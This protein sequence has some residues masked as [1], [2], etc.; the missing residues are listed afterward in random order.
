[1]HVVVDTVAESLS[2]SAEKIEEKTETT[3]A[4][5]SEQVTLTTIPTTESSLKVISPSESHEELESRKDTDD[6]KG[7]QSKV[8][9][10][11][12]PDNLY[13]PEDS[14]QTTTMNSIEKKRPVEG[15]GT[16]VSLDIPVNSHNLTTTTEE[17]SILFD[18]N[19]DAANEAEL[20]TPQTDKINVTITESKDKNSLEAPTTYQD[21][22]T[23]MYTVTSRNGQTGIN[24]FFH[25][26]TLTTTGLFSYTTEVSSTEMNTEA[27]DYTAEEASKTTAL[28][29]S[30]N[31]LETKEFMDVPQSNG[32][33]EFNKNKES[34]IQTTDSA[35]E[36]RTSITELLTTELS[37][38]PSS[39][40]A[41]SGNP[42]NALT[43]VITDRIT[44]DTYY[45]Q[46][47]ETTALPD[48]VNAQANVNSHLNAEKEEQSL[49][50]IDEKLSKDTAENKPSTL[51]IGEKLLGNSEEKS[52]E[53][54]TEKP[55]SLNVSTQGNL[56][57]NPADVTSRTSAVNRTPLTIPF[58][59]QFATI[60]TEMNKNPGPLP[61]VEKKD[62][63]FTSASLEK[64]SSNILS[65]E[66]STLENTTE[67]LTTV[68]K[69]SGRPKVKVGTTSLLLVG[70]NY[71]SMEAA[72]SEIETRFSSSATEPNI[73][74][75]TTSKTTHTP[76]GFKKKSADLSSDTVSRNETSV[77]D[78]TT[79]QSV[80]NRD[81]QK[82]PNEE[83]SLT[84]STNSKQQSRCETNKAKEV[85]AESD[86][87]NPPNITKVDSE[88][89][90]K[91]KKNKNSEKTLSAKST[92]KHSQSKKNRT[93]S[94][95]AEIKLQE[96]TEI[97]AEFD[98]DDPAE[99]IRQ[100]WRRALDELRQRL[101]AHLEKRRKMNSNKNN[102][103]SDATVIAKEN[104]DAGVDEQ[105]GHRYIIQVV[106][107]V[108]KE[109][110]S[111]AK[112][113]RPQVSLLRSDSEEGEPIL[114]AEQSLKTL[115]DEKQKSNVS[116]E[117]VAPEKGDDKTE[118]LKTAKPLT[119]FPS[120]DNETKGK[121]EKADGI[122]LSFAG[123]PTKKEF[124]SEEARVINQTSLLIAENTTKVSNDVLEDAKFEKIVE[125]ENLTLL[126]E[127]E[128]FDLNGTEEEKFGV[129]DLSE[130]YTA[131]PKETPKE[132][133]TSILY[134]QDS[135]E[136]FHNVGIT[137][138]TEPTVSAASSQPLKIKEDL[139]TS[140][141]GTHGSEGT[142]VSN[143]TNTEVLEETKNT[144][145]PLK[146][147]TD[148]ISE[149]RSD[150]IIILRLEPK[151]KL[152][153]AV[154]N[155]EVALVVDD[156]YE[157]RRVTETEVVG[158]VESGK[159]LESGEKY[160]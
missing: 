122:L 137:L 76:S 144:S 95:R 40:N 61:T 116:D 11:P 48:V 130:N 46:G 73:L 91:A 49:T 129:L 108:V 140:K 82:A 24:E 19:K 62:K 159:N 107:S 31:K 97:V 36:M 12:L 1:M 86:L 158:A 152:L 60:T 39:T 99:K 119:K 59:D 111:D 125:N 18:T 81:E 112:S 4:N 131:I 151:E 52:V 15:S 134:D 104:S 67:L 80:I 148:G 42:E 109:H 20:A 27:N 89:S 138:T 105:D 98:P 57:Q 90:Q 78:F 126:R 17:N 128:S 72:E 106:R 8:A 6:D 77:F 155:P 87:T 142:F 30:S 143:A 34:A 54:T 66:Q 157:S 149:E 132:T 139:M 118:K 32:K 5:K 94:E 9:S 75:T 58:N 71:D 150:E 141:I 121:S 113:N 65:S 127:I 92:K 84:N 85:T 114:T 133:T 110:R 68:V 69:N 53:T 135:S 115:L 146:T 44:T 45:S 38:T 103:G 156:N 153:K 41:N 136:N 51:P 64:N 22:T 96:S 21:K 117:L 26:S 47:Y 74:S 147:E 93:K 50:N 83:L 70:E 55:K 79:Q 124:K 33:T 63:L 120:H 13:N 56:L 25:P 101:R 14:L 102:F 28:P 88:V 35:V 37:T 29:I 160:E 100:G 154:K 23:D 43:E 2:K 145:K 10:K 3:A 16:N 7:V 123:V